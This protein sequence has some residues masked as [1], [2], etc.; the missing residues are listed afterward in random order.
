MKISTVLQRASF[1]SLR[2]G[3][4]GSVPRPVSS[5]GKHLVRHTVA[6]AIMGGVSVAALAQGNPI[7]VGVVTPN[8]GGM[9]VIGDDLARN[10]ELA[11][12][13][14]NGAMTI[15]RFVLEQ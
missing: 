5:L 6:L 14:I 2:E 8:A 4:L 1:S 10:Y 12:D 7:K 3:L 13:Q 15:V 9:A 11:A